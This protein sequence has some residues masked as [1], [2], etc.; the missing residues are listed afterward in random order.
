MQPAGKLLLAL[1][2]S[3]MTYEKQV[4]NAFLA[5]ILTSS[6][7]GSTRIFAEKGRAAKR[8]RGCMGPT[9]GEYSRTTEVR[10]KGRY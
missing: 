4:K 7:Q 10:H 2:G 6:E 9:V 1:V 5:A 8:G 3:L